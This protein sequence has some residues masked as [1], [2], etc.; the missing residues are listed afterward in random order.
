MDEKIEKLSLYDEDGT[1][2]IFQVITKIDIEEREYIIVI[3]EDEMDAEEAIALKIEQ[4]EDGNDVLVTVEDDEEL[5]EVSEAYENSFK[6][7]PLN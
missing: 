1:E 7:R 6:D 2:M 4:D 3:P 5:E